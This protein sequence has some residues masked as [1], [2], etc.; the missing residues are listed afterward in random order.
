[1]SKPYKVVATPYFR[2]SLQRLSSFLDRKYSPQHAASNKKTLKK[3]IQST[4]PT[5]S[6]I[7]PISSR[8]LALGVTSH[9]QWLIDEHNVIFYRVSDNTKEVILLLVMDSRQDIQKLLYDL[10]LQK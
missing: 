9:H 4:L 8:L 5:Q 6:R 10:V 7:A 2:L 3:K 1:M